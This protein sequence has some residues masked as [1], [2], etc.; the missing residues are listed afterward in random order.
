M[1]KGAINHISNRGK[2]MGLWKL[3]ILAI[4]RKLFGVMI[5]LNT[6]KNVFQK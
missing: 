1:P 4:S 3:K 5:A 2:D 6:E